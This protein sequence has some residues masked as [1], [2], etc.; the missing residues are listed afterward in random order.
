MSSGRVQAFDAATGNQV[1]EEYTDPK[2]AFRVGSSLPSVKLRFSGYDPRTGDQ[3]ASEYYMDKGTIAAAD[4]VA[5]T[6]AGANVGTVVLAPGGSIAGRVTSEA[7]APGA[8]R[9]GVLQPRRL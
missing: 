2:G 3:L 7:G 8:P 6:A 9:P 5:P 1:G 4:A